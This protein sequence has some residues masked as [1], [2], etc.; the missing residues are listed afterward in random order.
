MVGCLVNVPCGSCRCR[1]GG[2]FSLNRHPLI[3]GTQCLV[4]FRA[5]AYFRGLSICRVAGVCPAT[6]LVLFLRFA[7]C[8]LFGIVVIRAGGAVDRHPDL[9]VPPALTVMIDLDDP[10][11]RWL[12]PQ[13]GWHHAAAAAEPPARVL[14]SR[15]QLLGAIVTRVVTW[16]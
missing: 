8:A 1:A 5:S 10:A 14:R 6:V 12:P 11:V 3:H 2:D 15:L 16:L 4:V 9:L 7:I 13:A